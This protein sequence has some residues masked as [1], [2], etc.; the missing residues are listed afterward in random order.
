MSPDI[1]P[2]QIFPK[3]VWDQPERRGDIFFETFAFLIVTQGTHEASLGV[4]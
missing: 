1:T 3:G 4:R 2:R